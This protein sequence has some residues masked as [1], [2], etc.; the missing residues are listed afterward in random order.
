MRI[1]LI[2]VT[3]FASNSLKRKKNLIGREKTLEL[4]EIAKENDYRFF[5]YGDAMLILRDE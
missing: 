1:R 3:A 5:S 2:I 4:Y